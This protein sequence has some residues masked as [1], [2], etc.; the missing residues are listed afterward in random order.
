MLLGPCLEVSA[1]KG[2]DVDRGVWHSC[3]SRTAQTDKHLLVAFRKLVN[4]SGQAL[5]HAVVQKGGRARADSR[6]TYLL[7]AFCAGTQRRVQVGIFLLREVFPN[8]L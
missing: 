2:L 3:C 1:K 7:I 5:T 6:P 4:R 8:E